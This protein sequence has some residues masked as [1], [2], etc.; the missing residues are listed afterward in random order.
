MCDTSQL[1]RKCRRFGMIG[2][3][4]KFSYA[5]RENKCRL[6]ES[7]RSNEVRVTLYPNDRGCRCRRRDVSLLPRSVEGYKIISVPVYEKNRYLA[8]RSKGISV[9]VHGYCSCLHPH[10]HCR[11][12][13]THGIRR[14]FLA[15]PSLEL[16]VRIPPWAWMS[17][18]CECCVLSGRGLCD[19]PITRSKESYWLCCVWVWSWRVDNEEALAH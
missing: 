12:Q 2:C 15:A 11:S 1:A 19:G 16:W 3:E 6:E 13:W 4:W 18:S 14:G 5:T 9:F 17:V 7:E 10:Q 8:S